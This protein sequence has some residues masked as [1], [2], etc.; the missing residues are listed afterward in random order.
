MIVVRDVMRMKFGKAKDVKAL[1]REF[2]KMMPKA[3]RKKGRILFDY[4]GPAYTMVLEWTYENLTDF[5]K[6]M[7]SDM[8]NEDWGKWYQRFIPLMESSYREVFTV[9]EP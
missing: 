3:D 2:N 1:M 4:I 5:E 9:F 8:G 7:S 6:R